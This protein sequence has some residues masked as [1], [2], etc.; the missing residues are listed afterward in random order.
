MQAEP[1]A[2][3]ATNGLT[4]HYGKVQALVDLTL[5]VRAGQIFGFL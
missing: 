2:V 5:D 4:K 1:I 3:I